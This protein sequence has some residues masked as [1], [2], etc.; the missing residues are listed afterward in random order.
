MRR[1]DTPI[2]ADANDAVGLVM[3]KDSHAALAA[4]SAF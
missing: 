2:V 1:P 4:M 3:R